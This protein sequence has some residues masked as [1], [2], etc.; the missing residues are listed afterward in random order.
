MFFTGTTV[1][2]G[3][4]EKEMGDLYNLFDVFAL[5]TSGEGFGIPTIEAMACEIPVV[6]TD[7]TTTKEIV[8]DNKAGIAAKV[9]ETIIGTYN[10]QRA[11]ADKK[12]FA[13]K[14]QIMFDDEN[15][16]K[17]FGRNGRKAVVEKYSWKVVMPRWVD[18]FREAVK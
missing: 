5:C 7:F 13:D 18:A 11:I 16:R 10:V 3:F 14:L 15:M 9:A 1:D 12:D 17:E 2:H 8:L 4:T 6:A